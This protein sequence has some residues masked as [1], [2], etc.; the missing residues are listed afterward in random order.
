MDDLR[1]LKND[2]RILKKE[3]ASY[4][5]K[6][7]LQ[8]Q[9]WET[10]NSLTF[11]VT[12]LDD[13]PSL[14][15]E[16]EVSL[17]ITCVAKNEGPYLKEWIEYHKI[18]GVERFYFYDNESSDNTKEILEPYINDGTVVYH[19]LPNHPITRQAPQIEA[20]NDAIYRYRDITRWM[21]IIDA[22]EFIV[23]IENNSISEFLDDYVQYPAVAVNW[24]CFD[25][26]GHIKKPTAHGGLLTANY[27]RVKENHNN[28][29]DRV[30]KCIVNPKKVLHYSIH[31]GLYYKNYLAVTE[32]FQHMR[33]NATQSH[34]SSK[35]RINH[36]VTKS[37]EE[38]VNKISRNS[39]NNPTSGGC[40]VLESRLNFTGGG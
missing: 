19:F 40:Y 38:Y 34:S 23:P 11:R 31:N 18:V 12:P 2:I 39:G 5:N 37:K 28:D 16:T 30:V 3:F 36:Y 10:L 8:M 26:N 35:I 6:H 4:K 9:E 15:P 33:G 1:L 7:D 20:Y 13:S 29:M 25:S 27:T 32:N 24:V 17:A 14:G 22:D 21:A